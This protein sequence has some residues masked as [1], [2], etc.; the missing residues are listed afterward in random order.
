M[1]PHPLRRMGFQF[2][3]SGLVVVTLM[4]GYLLWINFLTYR[5]LDTSL[6]RG[7]DVIGWPYPIATMTPVFR[8]ETRLVGKSGPLAPGESR[9]MEMKFT[10][11]SK[12]VDRRYEWIP[13][14]MAADAAVALGI[15]IAIAIL[16]EVGVRYRLARRDGV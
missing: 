16:A 6:S 10:D 4:S 12:I 3:L 7:V 2:H 14:Y 11:K 13:A 8:E 15:T 5:G 9:T 1:P